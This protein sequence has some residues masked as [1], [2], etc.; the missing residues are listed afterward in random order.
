M[1][2]NRLAAIYT[3]VSSEQ[4]KEAQ[5]IDSQVAALLEYAQRENYQVPEQWVFRDEGYSG[6][7]LRRPGLDQIRD[8]AAEQQ[9]EAILIYSPDRLSRN[10]AYQV[11][12]IEELNGQGAEVVFM[13]APQTDSP[14]STLLVQFQGMIAEYERAL[15][16]ERSR[17][18]KRHKAKTGCISVLSGAPYG[19]RYVKKTQYTAAYYEIIETQATVVRQIYQLYTEEF[20]SIAAITRWLEEQ[21][22]TT[23]KGKS[24]WDRSTIWAMLRNPAYMGKACF[25]KTQVAERQKITRPLRQKGG[26]SPR[27]SANRERPREDWIEIPVP[28]IISS[29]TFELAQQRLQK[30]KQLA[31]R[32]TVEHTLLQGMLVCNHCGYSYYRTSTKTSKKKIHYYRC[33]GSDDYRYKNG[34]ICPSRPIRQDYLD[35]LVWLHLIR[36]LE[37]PDLIHQEIRKRTEQ[38]VSSDPIR[39]RKDKL[40][41]QK[42]KLEKSIDKL[43]DAYQEHLISLTELRKRIPALRKRKNTLNAELNS[44]DAKTLFQEQNQNII[45]DVES[46]LA[47]LQLNENMLDIETKRKIL[48]LLVKEILIKDKSIIINHCIKVKGKV[49]RQTEQCYPLR[50][51]SKRTTL[52]CALIPRLFNAVYHHATAQVSL[53]QMDYASILYPFT[54]LT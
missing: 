48:Q 9:L 7:M 47:Q 19:Y 54:Q 25:G 16:K 4:Q 12:L 28:A 33:L 14:E 50:G 15:I 21:N 41:K 46:F 1:M 42:A 20:W 18:G 38:A 44:L 39:I 35:E 11:I 6:S 30:N 49:G 52:R 40:V 3:R 53:Y 32:R 26:Y 22:I 45:Q 29:D 36:L 2:M 13:N 37:E 17:R 5:T 23:K 8:L 27:C 51:G 10:Y 43:L 31:A 34:R 24:N